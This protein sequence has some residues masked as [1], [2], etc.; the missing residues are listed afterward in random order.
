[1]TVKRGQRHDLVALRE[2][3]R[4]ERAWCDLRQSG[5]DGGYMGRRLDES[6]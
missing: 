6:V 2:N 1:M 4:D 3:D 5:R